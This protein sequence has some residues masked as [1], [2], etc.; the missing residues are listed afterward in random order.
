MQLLIF[1]EELEKLV[2]EDALIPI[3][4]GIDYEILQMLDD[5]RK[6]NVSRTIG[7]DDDSLQLYSGL[8]LA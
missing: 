5:L 7:I 3:S 8:L 2:T 4:V 1:M 6:L